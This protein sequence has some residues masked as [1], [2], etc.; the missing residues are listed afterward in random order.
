M[1]GR[2][3]VHWLVFCAIWAGLLLPLLSVSSKAV[4][5]DPQET[6]EKSSETAKESVWV[7]WRFTEP[8]ARAV[9]SIDGEEVWRAKN[10]EGHRIEELAEI[11]W[12]SGKLELEMIVEWD[13]DGH[14]AV[15]LKLEPIDAAPV[16]VTRF[17]EGKL[18]REKVV[19]ER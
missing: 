5:E 16:V 6:R 18:M 1:R 14:R 3:L 13:A 19:V 2:P 4:K 15:E 12:P 7:N 11:G 10:P 8:P 9:I 17:S